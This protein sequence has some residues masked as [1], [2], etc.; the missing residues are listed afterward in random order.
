MVRGPA[1]WAKP[2]LFRTPGD[3]ATLP[4]MLQRLVLALSLVVACGGEA[5]IDPPIGAGGASTTT[6][7][8]GGASTTG[9]TNVAVSTSTGA[10][11]N[12]FAACASLQACESFPPGFSCVDQCR[13]VN[14]SPNC[15]GAHNDFLACSLGESGS[16]CGSIP[17]VACSTS[18]DEWLACT[19]KVLTEDCAVSPQGDCSCNAFVSPGIEYDQICNP[20]MGCDCLI[21][22]QLVGRCEPNDELC[23]ITNGCCSGIFF[24]GPF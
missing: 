17:A 7:G 16:L 21:G 3:E 2:C 18:L 23:G 10:M 24:T 15:G 6:S 1:P 13:I 20:G 9:V 11:D 19:S 5:V 4:D 22:G 12:C 14:D 8:A